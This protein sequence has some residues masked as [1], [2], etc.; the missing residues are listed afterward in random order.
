MVTYTKRGEDLD[1]RHEHVG[2]AE[3]RESSKCGCSAYVEREAGGV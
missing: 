2:G 1:K 3:R